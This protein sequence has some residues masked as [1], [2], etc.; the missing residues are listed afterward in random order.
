MHDL[1][2]S[3]IHRPPP[4]QFKHEK[5]RPATVEGG[6]RQD[7][8]QSK[9]EAEQ[10]NHADDRQDARLRRLRRRLNDADRSLETIGTEQATETLVSRQ[11]VD[12]TDNADDRVARFLD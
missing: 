5:G 2:A 9:A 1:L 8:R 3:G 11:L 7:V 12:A 10:R 4:D 6:K